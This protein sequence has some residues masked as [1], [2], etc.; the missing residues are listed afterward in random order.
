MNSAVSNLCAGLQLEE[1]ELSMSTITQGPT[2]PIADVAML[3]E[4][5]LLASTP[6]H[7]CGD[8]TPSS[9]MA[10]S[11]SP[12]NSACFSPPDAVTE[13]L[14]M[15]PAGSQS[16]QESHRLLPSDAVA[17]PDDTSVWQG[18]KIVGD[19]IDKTVHHRYQ[20]MGDETI[21]LHYFNAY[22]VKDR[23]NFSTLSNETKNLPSPLPLHILLPS[24]GD[25]KE[26]NHNLGILVMRMLVRY[27]PALQPLQSLVPD[28]IPH[29]HSIKMSQR[30]E[31]VCTVCQYN[32]HAG[33]HC[34]PNSIIMS[35][36]II[37]L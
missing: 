9:P 28:H 22:A 19:N 32:L 35:A 7:Q 1:L 12:I 36:Y 17:S 14:T 8:D 18:F 33:Q 10:P 6:M 21:S 26:M 2:S 37:I 3:S 31:T 5:P 24:E 11:F 15:T 20:R 29:I 16:P 34:R 30:S 23:I 25:L 13:P 4:L 27:M